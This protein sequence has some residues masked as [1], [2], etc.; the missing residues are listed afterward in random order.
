M[1]REGDP[2]NLKKLAER[3]KKE[4]V[5]MGSLGLSA[6]YLTVAAVKASSSS[7]DFE[8]IQTDGVLMSVDLRPFFD[9]PIEQSYAGYFLASVMTPRI[10]V[11]LDT[12]LWSLARL[13]GPEL[14]K[15]MS[16]KQHL[17]HF[18]YQQKQFMLP[19]LRPDDW[20]SLPAHLSSGD[21]GIQLKN[22]V[23]FSNMGSFKSSFNSQYSWGSVRAVYPV[24]VMGYPGYAS[25]ILQQ[26][27]CDFMVYNLFHWAGSNNT[28][29]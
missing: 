8:G 12:R 10:S 13:L 7:E 4:G 16:E 19:L 1:C 23:H 22:D 21:W 9:P 27:S 20:S 24:G 15:Q 11:G 14:M 2:E 6:A 18:E 3:C 17:L 29:G 5:T 28:A 25:Y 26:S